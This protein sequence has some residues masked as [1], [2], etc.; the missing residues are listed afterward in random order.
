MDTHGNTVLV[1]GGA[2]GIGLAIAQA[3]ADLG[4][5][6]LICGRNPQ[7][8][9]EARRANPSLHAFRCDISKPE[10][11]ERM[12]EGIAE[13]HRGLN[14][15]VNN[16][17]IGLLSSDFPFDDEALSKAEREIETNLVG[18][19]R[20][21]KAALPFLLR[22]GD[23]G[24]I[25]ISSIL[26]IVPMP[27]TAIYSATKAALH[28][29]SISLRHQLRST[30]VRVFEVMPSTVDTDLGRTI[31]GARLSPETVARAVLTG[32]RRETFEIH[33]GFP[34]KA[35]YAAHR[36]SPGVAEILLRRATSGPAEPA[37]EPRNV[38]R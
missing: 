14:V 28:S 15:L 34:A 36:I 21:T 16:A 26:A 8:L 11:V 19:L 12:F 29:F 10:D 7:R 30:R 17:G 13:E 31:P 1:T 3:F 33:V 24:V 9:E 23:A 38:N 35:L 4:N 5:H 37:G 32:V 18:P 27:R 20:V 2:S 6:V 22:N 25:T